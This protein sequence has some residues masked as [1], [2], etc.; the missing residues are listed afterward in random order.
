LIADGVPPGPLFQRLKNG[1]TVTLADGRII[2]GEDFSPRQH[3]GK[4]W[5][6]SAIPPRALPR[7]NWLRVST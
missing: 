2:R 1:E 3:R 6:F 7:C 5:P 4:N